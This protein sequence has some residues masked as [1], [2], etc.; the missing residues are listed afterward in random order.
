MKFEMKKK[1]ND[2]WGRRPLVTDELN[3][4][5]VKYAELDKIHRLYK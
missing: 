5:N 1:V 2:V 3:I 4:Y